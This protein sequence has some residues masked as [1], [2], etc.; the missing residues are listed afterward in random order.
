MTTCRICSSPFIHARHLC[1]DCYSNRSPTD[2][3]CR[4]D[5]GVS[6]EPD[7]YTVHLPKGASLR[8][9]LID[10][11]TYDECS[12]AH[13]LKRWYWRPTAREFTPLNFHLN[14]EG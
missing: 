8:G 9:T 6:S 13:A 2:F 1:H 7:T 12:E 11:C 14:D 10:T 4:Q 3:A 5:V